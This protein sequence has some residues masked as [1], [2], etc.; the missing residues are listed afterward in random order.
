MALLSERQKTA[1]RLTRELQS[2]GAT[3][4]SVLPLAGDKHLRFWVSDYKKNE[5]LQQLADAGYEPIFTGMTPQV[6]VQTYS[7]GFVNCFELHLPR[8]AQAV[9]TAERRRIPDAVLASSEPKSSYEVEHVMRYLG[10]GSKK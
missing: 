7:M 4:T 10:M 3:V 8:E 6:D 1:E 2:L 9:P 5:L